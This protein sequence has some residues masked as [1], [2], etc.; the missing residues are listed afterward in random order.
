MP[1]RP[2]TAVVLAA[3]KTTP[4]LGALFGKTSSAMI[5]VNGRLRGNDATLTAD[6]QEIK[7]RVNGNR[8]EAT[9]STGGAKPSSVVFTRVS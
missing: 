8:I 4:A 1:L 9:S 5:P 3:G 7:G 6:K 2:K